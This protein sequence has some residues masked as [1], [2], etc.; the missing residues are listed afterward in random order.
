MTHD[1]GPSATKRDEE[2]D[3]DEDADED[4]DRMG[5]ACDVLVRRGQL[6]EQSAHLSSA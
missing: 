6:L 2:R 3:K 4:A 5:Y 1:A